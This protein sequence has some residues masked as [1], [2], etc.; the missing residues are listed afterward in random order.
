MLPDTADT[1][2]TAPA[3]TLTN[4]HKQYGTVCAVQHL[5]LTV[6]TGELLTLVGPSGCGKS[7]LLRLIT[8]LERPDAG[9]IAI[10]G[11]T[12]AGNG[13]LLPP[14]ARRVSLVFQDYAL[15][16]HMTIADNIMFG[17]QGWQRDERQQRVRDVLALVQLPDIARRYPHELSGGQQQRVA[18][19]RALAPHPAVVLLD[20]PFSNLDRALRNTLRDDVR[21]ALRA[22]HTTAILVTHD[23]E[24][25]LLLGDRVAVMQ[26]GRLLQLATPH[27]IYLTPATR[28]VAAFIGD[29]TFI[30]GDAQG[31]AVAT[32]LGQARLARPVQGTVD[33]L[34]RP[35]ALSIALVG[36]AATSDHSAGSNGAIEQITFYGHDQVASVRLD[37]GGQ[38]AVRTPPRRD[39]CAGRRVV[40]QVQGEVVAFPPEER[41]A[42]GCGTG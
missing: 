18:L 37:N 31:D 34:L 23:Q 14:E 19:A 42:D 4:I 28:T 41:T 3:L 13:V 16:P 36:D 40:V 27:D 17:L 10:N 15:F 7:T 9:S 24:E 2:D 5:S 38:V 6:P 21:A 33:V 22:N 29:A 39:L 11:R 32:P 26:D 20:E 25:A 12:V 35:E 1:A 30:A 8:G